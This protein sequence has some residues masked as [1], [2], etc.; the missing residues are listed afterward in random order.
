M[1]LVRYT[2]WG[3]IVTRLVHQLRG[4]F[5]ALRVGSHGLR[6]LLIAFAVLALSASL[7]FGAQP[8]S[9]G[10]TNA[11]LHAGKTVPVQAQEATAGDEDTDASTEEDAESAEEADAAENCSTD[12]TALTGRSW[13]PCG[14]GRSC[15]GRRTRP[16]GPRGSRATAPSSS[17]GPT[18]ARRPTRRRVLRTGG[19][20]DRPCVDHAWRIGGTRPGQGPQQITPGAAS[21]P[22]ASAVHEESLARGEPG[23]ALVRSVP[24]VA[25]V[26]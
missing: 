16:S 10:L 13:P 19:R 18:R 12:P 11:S 8:T 9:T 6:G 7:A 2:L 21:G 5:H 3:A 17:A 14:T 24:P 23:E 4:S 1:V 26:G 25:A 22:A 15:A 20:G